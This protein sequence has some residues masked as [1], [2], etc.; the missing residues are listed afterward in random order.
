MVLFQEATPTSH[1]EESLDKVFVNQSRA[2]LKAGTLEFDY[3]NLCKCISLQISIM[4]KHCSNHNKCVV[5]V[6]HI[7]SR[8]L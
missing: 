8:Q 4:T 3:Y 2:L 7:F 6:Q 5:C 1:G